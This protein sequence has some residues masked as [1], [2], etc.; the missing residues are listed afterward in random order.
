MRGGDTQNVTSLKMSPEHK[1]CGKVGNSV[2]HIHIYASLDWQRVRKI[3]T[4]IFQLIEVER[5]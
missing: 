4:G 2:A 3:A 5:K 1:M